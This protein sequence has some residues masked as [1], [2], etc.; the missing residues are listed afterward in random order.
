MAPLPAAREEWEDLNGFDLHELYGSQATME[1][2]LQYAAGARILH[3]STHAFAGETPRIELFDHALLLPDIYTMPIGAD[4][5]V[6]SACQ[7]GLGR[8]QKGEGVMS[9]ARAFASSGAAAV[10]S[11]LWSVND[12]STARLFQRFYFHLGE[13]LATGEALRQAK[14]DYLADASVGAAGQSPYFWAGFLAVGAE[15]EIEG[16][17]KLVRAVWWAAGILLLLGL[18]FFLWKRNPHLSKGFPF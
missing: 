18:L 10:I 13:N 1:Q 6:L 17:N 5:V 2:L 7:T 11:S 15:R 8:E 16:D 3:F 9:L 14:L 12:R 4:L